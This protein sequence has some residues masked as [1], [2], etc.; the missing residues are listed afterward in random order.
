MAMQTGLGV[1][2]ILFVVGAGTCSVEYSAFVF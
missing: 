2:K 1:S